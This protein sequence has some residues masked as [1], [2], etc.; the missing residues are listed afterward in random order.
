[1]SAE[2]KQMDSLF[3]PPVFKSSNPALNSSTDEIF[4]MQM[5]TKETCPEPNTSEGIDGKEDAGVDDEDQK[6]DEIEKKK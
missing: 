1:M 3:R 4:D 6:N 2:Q 5:W